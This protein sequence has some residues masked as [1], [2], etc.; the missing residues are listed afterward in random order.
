[1]HTSPMTNA[2]SDP[3]SSDGNNAP[4][5]GGLLRGLSARFDSKQEKSAALPEAPEQ[6]AVVVR[7]VPD[8]YCLDDFEEMQRKE[9]RASVREVPEESEGESTRAKEDV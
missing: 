6:V 9:Q 7:R 1:M 5:P 4:R 3:A 8:P 2:S